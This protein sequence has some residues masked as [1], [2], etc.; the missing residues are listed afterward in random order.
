MLCLAG[1]AWCR[2]GMKK[3]G[4]KTFET[5]IS[6]GCLVNGRLFHDCGEFI[7][8]YLAVVVFVKLVYHSL[9]LV[10]ARRAGMTQ[11]FD[12]FLFKNQQNNLFFSSIHYAK[13]E[14]LR[15]EHSAYS[16]QGL[17]CMCMHAHIAGAQ[18]FFRGVEHYV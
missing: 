6:F 8:V 13:K 5:L 10:V 16:S 17:G 4:A 2:I 9:Q 3:K 1:I 11:S 12:R 15:R 7:E 14:C 18:P